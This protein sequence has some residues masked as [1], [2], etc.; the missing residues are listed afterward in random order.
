M[1]ASTIPYFSTQAAADLWSLREEQLELYTSGDFAS[2]LS[3]PGVTMHLPIA[4]DID[5]IKDLDGTLS[6]FDSAKI[7]WSA[8]K[9]LTPSLARENRLWSRL[10]HGE[11]LSY[12]RNRWLRNSTPANLVEQIGIHCFARTLTA[13]RDDNALGRLWWSGFIASKFAPDFAEE[14]LSLLLKT[15]DIRSNFVERT[16]MT[17][18]KPV[19]RA[20]LR[21]M[22]DDPWMTLAERNFRECMKSLNVVGA[23]IAFEVLTERQADS[24]IKSAIEKAR[25][26]AS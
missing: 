20:L 8:L 21:A 15:A 7:V 6:D 16:W 19:A 3:G 17:T 18:R 11:G 25:C 14:A 10:C 2:F 4:G 23:G 12:T 24:L 1:T 22:R 13:C 26:V 9:N 5:A